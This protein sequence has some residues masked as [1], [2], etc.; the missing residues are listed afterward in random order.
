VLAGADPGFF[1]GGGAAKYVDPNFF[2]GGAQ[3]RF[4][5]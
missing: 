5:R 4:I 1:F 2:L 3:N